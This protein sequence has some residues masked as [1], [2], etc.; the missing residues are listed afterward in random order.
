MDIYKVTT[1]NTCTGRY[2]EVEVSKEVYEA[3]KRS[4]WTEQNK[5]RSFYA[6]QSTFSSLV[7]GESIDNFHE[8]VEISQRHYEIQYYSAPELD[9]AAAIHKAFACLTD[10]ELKLIKD[11]YV[12]R[13]TEQEIA[14]ATNVSQQAVHKRK[15]R[16]LAKLR[17]AVSKILSSEGL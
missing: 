1:Y 5:D 4:Y 15:M 3:Y 8:L 9:R 6:H 10:S 2:E 7:G 14:D 13:K 11:I 17:K 16:I 12:F